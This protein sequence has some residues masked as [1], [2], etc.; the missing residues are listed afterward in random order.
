MKANV[1]FN[2]PTRIRVPRMA[3]AQDP[4][5]FWQPSGDTM[6]RGSNNRYENK[7]LIKNVNDV[8]FCPFCAPLIKKGVRSAGKLGIVFRLY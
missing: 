4:G 2:R 8:H 3:G 5:A 6:D 1:S 7:I